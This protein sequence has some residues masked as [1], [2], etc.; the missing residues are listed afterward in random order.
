M[1]KKEILVGLT[2][3]LALVLLFV[4]INFLKGVNVFK[5]ANYYYATYTD[6]AGLSTSAP[7][8]INGFKVGQVRSVEY[9]YD[10]PGHVVVEF[11]V[12]KALRI[13]QGSQAVI[14]TDLLGTATIA[15]R[16]GA[17]RS[18][19]YSVG[20]TV[21]TGVDAGLMSAVSNDVM[22]AVSA[23]IPKIDSL[24][25]GLNTLVS[26]PALSASVRR[27]DNITADLGASVQSLRTVMAAMEP[28]S[29]NVTSI[30]AN[31]DT[32]SGNLST[33]SGELA[34][35]PVDSIMGELNRTVANLEQLTAALNNPDSSIGRLTSDPELYN[36]IN[37]TVMSLDSLFVDIKRNPK[38]YI[39]IKLL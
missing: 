18:A 10:N 17:D 32:I 5:A 6:V 27:M 3:A 36:N 12:D 21:A 2:V 9:Q 37:S 7:V 34:A 15:L 16:M 31:V 14:T 11:S 19:F 4:G 22:P 13:P 24:I 39:S 8:T 23:I 1:K 30:T 20:D 29:R 25:T 35:A 33:V 28:V 38:R 26:D